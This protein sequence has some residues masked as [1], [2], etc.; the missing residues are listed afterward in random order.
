MKKKTLSILAILMMVVFILTGCGEKEDEETETKKSKN[1]TEEVS[2]TSSVNWEEAYLEAFKDGTIKTGSN[3]RIRFIDKDFDGIPEMYYNYVDKSSEKYLSSPTNEDGL[4]TYAASAKISVQSNGEAKVFSSTSGEITKEDGIEYEFA[5]VHLLPTDEY[6]WATSSFG[7]EFS[8]NSR[9]E[10]KTY[11]ARTDR[12]TAIGSSEDIFEYV[13]IYIPKAVK[14][15]PSNI[16]EAFTTAYEKAVKNY[17]PNEELI[18]SI[19][20]EVDISEWA[21]IYKKYITEKDLL[22]PYSNAKITFIDIDDNNVPDMVYAY[23]NEENQVAIRTYKLTKAGNVVAV[24]GANNPPNYGMG[25]QYEVA[26]R[27]GYI[28]P[29]KRNGW[30]LTKP[31]GEILLTDDFVVD[32]LVPFYINSTTGP[33]TGMTQYNK[34]TFC[35]LVPESDMP[36]GAGE[37]TTID[38]TTFDEN[39]NTTFDAAASKYVPNSEI[40]KP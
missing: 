34:E 38:T 15:D 8:I 19:K 22:T 1:E 3:T 14:I 24:N 23:R 12:G 11:T 37:F 17:I 6:V 36:A 31:G 27:Y 5:F 29:L 30:V 32:G 21:T 18:K 26:V 2:K 25:Y 16:D 9:K 20:D 39:F 10:N 7:A 13:G 33:D 40:K 28:N 35:E 4:S